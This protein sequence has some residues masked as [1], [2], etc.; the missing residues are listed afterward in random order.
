MA[1]TSYASTTALSLG[2]V[3]PLLQSHEVRSHEL[4]ILLHMLRAL[5]GH[6]IN[7]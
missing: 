7:A 4:S 6:N 3:A 2:L 1:C 5:Q